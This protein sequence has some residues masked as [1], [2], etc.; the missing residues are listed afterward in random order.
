MG[1]HN[2][3]NDNN[4]EKKHYIARSQSFYLNTLK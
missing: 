3:G 1:K 2:V 4:N